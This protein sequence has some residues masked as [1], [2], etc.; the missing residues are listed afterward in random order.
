MTKYITIGDILKR[1][2]FIDAYL[3][4]DK[5]GLDRQVTWVHIVDVPEP[6]SFI[7]GGELV[8]C[9]GIG[10]ANRENGLFN[11]L[12]QLIKGQAAGLCIELGTAILEIPEHILQFANSENFPII[13]FPLQVHFVDITQDVHRLILMDQQELIDSLEDMFKNL[14][15]LTLNAAGAK[16]ILQYVHQATGYPTL[17]NRFHHKT[18]A[19]GNTV[20]IPPEIS[21]E[22]LFGSTLDTKPKIIHIP[23]SINQAEKQ[24]KVMIVQPVIVL[25]ISR[26]IFAI[27]ANQ[28]EVNNY[29]LLLTER[30]SSALSL[31]EFH[32]LS[33]EEKETFDE[34][35]WVDKVIHNENINFPTWKNLDKNQNKFYCAAVIAYTKHKKANTVEPSQNDDMDVE[36]DWPNKRMELS[37][38][39]RLAFTKQGF[40]PYLSVHHDNIIVI[41]E[42]E[43]KALPIKLRIQTSIQQ[44]K[45]AFL[46]CGIMSSYGV[47]NIVPSKKIYRSYENAIATWNIQVKAHIKEALFY[48]ELGIYKWIQLL[49][50]SESAY[51]LARLDIYKV[52]EYDEKHHVDLFLTLKTYLDCDCSKQ[53]TAEQL[54]IHRQTLYHRLKLLDQLIQIDFEDPLQRLSLHMSIYYIQYKD[55]A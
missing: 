40:R 17:Y 55:E 42:W 13:V 36:K 29:L 2:T 3:V 37:I 53:K 46:K 34:Q 39:V 30:I 47:G 41:L 15:Q 48:D 9:T 43:Q 45:Q 54:F 22:L 18:I 23:D 50:H 51:E 24:S 7:R 14:Q 20:E 52:L 19:F 12:Q 38:A 26:G 4:T 10:F 11:Y 6:L 21:Q 28:S 25:G 35:E 5:T 32:Q 1:Q 8:L 27:V 44:L 49:E 16:G 33:I 31:D